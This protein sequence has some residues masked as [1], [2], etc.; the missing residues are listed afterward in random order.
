MIFCDFDVYTVFKKYE[1]E[2]QSC[3]ISDVQLPM[4]NEILDP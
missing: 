3:R 1:T 4:S 2:I